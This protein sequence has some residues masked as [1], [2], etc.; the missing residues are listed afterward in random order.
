METTPTVSKTSSTKTFIPLLYFAPFF[1]TQ[2]PTQMSV[3]HSYKQALRN[4]RTG[5]GSFR[6]W[7]GLRTS[8]S[9]LYTLMIKPTVTNR[10]RHNIL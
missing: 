1:I 8:W 7:Q 9:V 6:D 10:G 5:T 3:Q 4:A 2:S